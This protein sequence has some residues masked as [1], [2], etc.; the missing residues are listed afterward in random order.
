MS[1]PKA[2]SKIV[3]AGHVDHG[4]STLFGRILMDCGAVPED[5]VRAVRRICEEKGIPLEPAFFLDALK[6]EQ[7]QGITIDTTRVQF[8][9]AGRRFLLIDAPGHLEFLKNMT[10][11]ASDADLGVLIVDA[12]EGM[13]EQTL[14]HL[15]IFSLL[16]L[17]ELVVVVNKLDKLGYDQARFAALAAEI[18]KAVK[19]EG[20]YCREIVPVSALLGENVLTKSSSMAWYAGPAL[21]P[22]LAEATERQ[23]D[24]AR[25]LAEPFRMVLQDVYRF[26]DLRHFAGRVVSGSLQPGAEVQF[27]PSGKL[28]RVEAIERWPQGSAPFARRGDSIA[29]RL[30]DQVFVERG[31]VVSLPGLTPKVDNRI[32][33]KLAWL[34]AEPFVPGA[35]YLLKIGTAEVPC[36][37]EPLAQGPIAN[38]VFF[39]CLVLA[40]SPV[41]FD[42][43]LG[44]DA[45]NKLVICSKY[46]TVA[47]GA[48]SAQISSRRKAMRANPDVRAE[49]GYV[50]R[51][52]REAVQSHKGAV[53]WLTG[54]SGSG[55]TS[56]AKALERELHAQGLRVIALDGDNLR[57]GLCADLGFTPEDRAENIRR[58]AHSAK[59]FLDAGF[60]VITAC[61]SPYAEDRQNAR[62]IIG[63]A[64]FKE[65]FLFCPIEVCRKRDAKGLYAKAGAGALQG[66]SGVGSPYQN[67]EHPDLRLDS[68]TMSVEEELAALRGLLQASGA[69]KEGS[70]A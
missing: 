54:L 37:L 66:L 22:L 68:S 48:V 19:A 67:P 47:A 5:R 38:G 33:A 20:L 34:G 32:G 35:A 64:D 56:L 58:V 63:A 29:L 8:E 43:T 21:L 41:A 9:H 28:A 55:K 4:K 53:L 24:P 30:S 18:E 70:R 61:I 36:T 59:L 49:T 12:V 6:E 13:R 69:L 11:G 1:A 65:I 15:K 57:K 23:E 46:E 16:G 3:I 27:S 2:M 52:E 62:E 40:E 51:E 31:E 25:D 39:D 42:E 26:N 17:A 60:I 45:L 50:R 10:T 44:R 7:D 14:R